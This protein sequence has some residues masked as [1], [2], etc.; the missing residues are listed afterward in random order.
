MKTARHQQ[1]FSLFIV[2]IVMLVIA[3]LV[4]VT[5]QSSTTEMRISANEADRK[6]ALSMAESGLRDAELR[7]QDFSTAAVGTVSFD[8]NCTGGLCLPAEP[9]NIVDTKPRFT[10]NGTV[11]NNPIE[12]WK[13]PSSA[14]SRKNLLEDPA[15]RN[16]VAGQARNSN[17]R[18]IIEYL[19]ERKDDKL[20]RYHFRVTARANGQNPNTAVTLQ[21]YV[22]MTPP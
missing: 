12:A 17:V 10:V 22:E 15:A 14:N 20:I 13:R 4:V 9:I 21:S 16:S 1:G 6:F 19:G 5:S 11:P 3:L 8:Y 7:I 2:M 18:Y